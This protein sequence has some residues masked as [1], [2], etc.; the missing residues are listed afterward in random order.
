MGLTKT[1]REVQWAKKRQRFPHRGRL[2]LAAARLEDADQERLWALVSAQSDG[3]SLRDM[4]REVGLSRSRVQQ[5]LA[6][7]PAQGVPTQANGAVRQASEDM[8]LRDRLAHEALLVR[9]AVGWFRDLL[10]G[11]GPKL[12]GRT[13]VLVNLNPD[14][15]RQQN[16]LFDE[17]RILK[18]L[19]RI[20]GDLDAWGR[21]HDLALPSDEALLRRYDLAAPPPP[22][23]EEILEEI[24]ARHR[25]PTSK[26]F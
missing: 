1:Q 25:T 5:L 21:G 7:E 23:D 9:Q 3:M 2:Q 26:R 11:R 13:W 4:A 19:E 22:T 8:T 18:V 10:E 16:Q 17:E 6:S 24:R 12:E 15:V 14:T 20:A